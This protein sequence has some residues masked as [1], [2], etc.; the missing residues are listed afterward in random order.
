MPAN[1]P[2]VWPFTRKDLVKHF[3]KWKALVEDG[4]FTDAVRL[5]ARK[6]LVEFMADRMYG[7][8]AQAVAI[9]ANQPLAAIVNIQLGDS[10]AGVIDVPLTP[11]GRDLLI[12]SKP[13]LVTE[14]NTSHDLPAEKK[15]LTSTPDCASAPPAGESSGLPDWLG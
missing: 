5:R 11:L 7:K 13:C 12:D 10:G 4:D 3:L 15:Q 2:K 9:T 6:E 14:N 1:K 8:P